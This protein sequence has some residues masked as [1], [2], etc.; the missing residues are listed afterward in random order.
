MLTLAST[1]ETRAALLRAAGIPVTIRPARV[2]EDATKAALA[3][4]G[5]VPRDVADALAEMKAVK[6]AA[7]GLTLGADQVLDDDGTLLS[8]PGGP[9]EAVAQLRALRGR[10]HRLIAAAVIAEEGYPVWRAVAEARLTMRDLSDRYIDDYVERNWEDVRHCVGAYRIEAEG[11][12][13]FARV[14]GSHFAVLGL[15]L[16]EVLDYLVLRGVV[17]S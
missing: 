2:D 3:A 1:S 12:R 10:T 7:P 5:A 8:K 13:L 16:L 15:P 14:E 6:H 4:E 9:A 17:A 11:V